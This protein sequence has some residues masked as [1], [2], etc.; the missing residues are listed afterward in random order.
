ME[1]K[2]D[3]APVT[4]PVVFS[5]DVF[6][7]FTLAPNV[8]E[9]YALLQSSDVKPE[10]TDEKKPD[11]PS[12][13]VKTVK[14]DEDSDVRN[15]LVSDEATSE[16][17][18]SQNHVKP[19]PVKTTKIFAFPEPLV[20]YPGFTTINAKQ[21]RSYLAIL[22]GK[23]V[24]YSKP[25]MERVR[26]EVTEFMIY[27]QDVSRACAD[28][29]NYMPPGSTRYSEEYFTACLEHVKSFPQFYSIQEITSLTN[30]K[31]VCE[32]S[33]NF[34]KQLLAMGKI[35]MLEKKVIP[36]DSQLAV[37]YETVSNVIPPAKKA[38]SA[39]TAISN[40]SNAEKLSATYEPQVCL[41][42]EAF[43][44]L[45]NNSSEFTEAW[46]LPIWVKMNP[47]KG[48]SQS[49]TAYI[50]PP[51]LKTEMS[52][53][54]RSLLF[55]EE[56]VKLAF[57]KTVS[58]PIF[59]LTSEEISLEMN[60]PPEDKISR[61]VVAVDDA[62]MDFETDL[63]DLESFGESY[64]PSK[65]VKEQNEPKTTCTNPSQLI[66]NPKKQTDSLGTTKHTSVSQNTPTEPLELTMAQEQGETN[67]SLA[68]G[69]NGA[70]DE[71]VVSEKES[72]S[73]DS[74]VSS[75]KCPPTKR[76]R[77]M[78]ED[79]VSDSD[80]ERLVIDHIVSPQRLQT[81]VTPGETSSPQAP[82]LA[83]PSPTNP[84][85][86]GTKKGIKRPRISSEC[87]QLGQILRMQDAMLKS[88]PSKNQEA[89]KPPVPE[90]KPP[91]PKTHSLVKQ[92]V[93]SY[94]ES[95]EGQGQGEDATLPAAVPV[96]VAPQRK[97]L[98]R[99]DLQVSAEDEMDYDPPAEGSVLYKLYSLLDIL[100]MVRSSVDIAHPRHDKKTFRA[101]PVH[102]LPKLEYQLCYGAESLTHTEACQLWAEKLLHSS[103][104][105]F[106]SRI[107]AHT[108]EVAQ[109]Q[110][111][112]DDWIQHI[113]CD[114]K[115]TRCL[116][117]L[118]HLLKKVSALQEGR[119][120]LVHKPREG[121]VTIFKASNETK[122]ARSLYHLQA[123]HCGP[124]AVSQGVPWVPLD[125]M[126]VLPFHQKHNR[127][128]CTFPPRPPI[129]A[130]VGTGPKQQQRKNAVRP[131]RAT[132]TTKPANPNQSPKK[133]NK[134]GARKTQGWVD[135]MRVKLMEDLQKSQ[136]SEGEKTPS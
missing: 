125:P 18:P 105:S 103:T 36:E 43:L 80:E 75:V 30:V 72:A 24:R 87:D 15:S 65:K 124:P 23:P 70:M 33:L 134:K 66:P 63:T 28:R 50:D 12:A 5:R 130:K 34:E 113:T 20:P 98:L 6:E 83:T 11:G 89:V 91:E 31:F 48:S 45:L 68:D 56:S 104:V 133:K 1:L 93:T 108:S 84:L 38:T 21:R 76:P 132:S 118:Y 119:Y 74:K 64:K 8:K 53:R 39:H 22:S 19:K 127:P 92:C 62:G 37:D 126:H 123:A 13:E 69:G 27:L 117:T 81:Q 55:H 71:S 16:C 29:Y 2:W 90:D 122:A 41:S 47:M 60:P 49:K 85:G 88:T 101:V 95:R 109:M 131:P 128:P 110:K 51:L 9:L 3:D 40:D 129:P 107:N 4:G 112:P 58:R 35:N 14:C 77:Q 97:R 78:M 100:L 32:I 17:E 136:T 120:L 82:D 96:L 79:K 102:V 114:F 111:L 44:Q 61:N 52:W 73:E 10:E 94:L 135:N 116:N 59:F 46:E 67:S 115:P 57:K 54:E 25:L 42:K 99:E 106:I 26:K 86:K 7:K 121:F